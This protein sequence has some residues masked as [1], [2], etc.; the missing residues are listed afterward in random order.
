MEAGTGGGTPQEQLQAALNR[1]ADAVGN[2]Q[3]RVNSDLTALRQQV[4]ELNAEHD[5]IDLTE[6]MVQID[7]IISVVAEIDPATVV[8]PPVEQPPVEQPPRH[9]RSTPPVEQPPV[10]Q[11][12]V[13]EP[14]PRSRLWATRPAT[15]ARSWATRASRPTRRRCTCTTATC[16]RPTPGPSVRQAC[17][18]RTANRCS[19]IR[20][21]RRVAP[22]Q[23]DN[24]GG[25]LARL[26]GAD[27][28]AVGST[29][30]ARRLWCCS[31]LRREVTWTGAST[32]SARGEVW[33][34]A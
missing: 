14:P 8:Q 11:P 29:E 22:P 1:L 15:R 2:M 34:A 9:R 19:P 32:W 10:E 27:R 20:A 16:P 28:R 25:E 5:D 24:I 4:D 31:H 21:T 7:S 26:P 30:A 23:G 33:V 6:I 13:E 12:P 17:R 3:G 18:R